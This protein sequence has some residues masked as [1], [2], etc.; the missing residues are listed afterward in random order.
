MEARSDHRIRRL[1]GLTLALSL[2]GSPAVA[3]HHFTW[4]TDIVVQTNPDAVVVESSTGASAPGGTGTQAS[5]GSNCYAE[6][7]G[8]IGSA[9]ID[10]VNQSNSLPYALVCD[11]ETVGVIWLPIDGGGGAPAPALSP[12]DI[13]MSLRDRIPIPDVTIAV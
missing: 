7:P 8:N 5:G 12:R 11:G 2:W 9:S 6:G 1:I 13:A 3:D 4:P 10:L